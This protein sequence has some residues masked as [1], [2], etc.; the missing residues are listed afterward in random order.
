MGQISWSPRAWVCPSTWWFSPLLGGRNQWHTTEH[1]KA[2]SKSHCHQ[3][4]ILILSSVTCNQSGVWLF[5][6]T[7][8]QPFRAIYLAPLLLKGTRNRPPW[9]ISSLSPQ[10]PCPILKAQTRHLSPTQLP[11]AEWWVV[12][13]G[14]PNSEKKSSCLDGN[15]ELLVRLTCPHPGR[16]GMPGPFIHSA[17][18]GCGPTMCQEHRALEDQWWTLK[19]INKQGRGLQ[20]KSSLSTK[21]SLFYCGK[22]D[23]TKFTSFKCTVQR[24]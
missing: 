4:G 24:H 10:G 2:T 8:L 3:E 21:W 13:F 11:V 19:N 9:E 15:H 23:I 16:M 1:I 5:V 7:T 17:G 20:T 22:I 18:N 6:L 14:E 12:C